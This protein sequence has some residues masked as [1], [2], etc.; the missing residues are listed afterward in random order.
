MGVGVEVVALANSR[1]G[2][3]CIRVQIKG[4]QLRCSRSAQIG[5]SGNSGGGSYYSDSPSSNG[6]DTIFLMV[7]ITLMEKSRNRRI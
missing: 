7:V 5:R 2:G 6:S 4:S 1:G 3:S